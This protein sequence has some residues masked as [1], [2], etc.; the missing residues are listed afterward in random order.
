MAE[1]GSAARVV[2]VR[3]ASSSVGVRLELVAVF[4]GTNDRSR[5][6]SGKAQRPELPRSRPHAEVAGLGA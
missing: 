1:G 4:D 2:H 3:P 6:I 5:S